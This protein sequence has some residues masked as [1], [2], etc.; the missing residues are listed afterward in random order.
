MGNLPCVCELLPA[1]PFPPRLRLVRLVI[2]LG[3]L[4]NGSAFHMIFLDN[5]K[6]SPF[7]TTGRFFF[8]VV[9]GGVESSVGFGSPERPRHPKIVGIAA[10]I[11]P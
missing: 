7:S 2:S 4:R 9:C 10:R 3:L 1:P 6:L 11:P 5:F 8:W